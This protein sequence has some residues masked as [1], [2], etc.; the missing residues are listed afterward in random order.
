MD[1]IDENADSEETMTQ[2]AE[3]VLEKLRAGMQRWVVLIGDGKT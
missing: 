3:I 2:V 1:L